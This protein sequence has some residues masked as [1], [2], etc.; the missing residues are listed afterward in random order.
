VAELALVDGPTL[1]RGGGKWQKLGGHFHL[2]EDQ[3]RPASPTAR[4][5]GAARGTVCWLSWPSLPHDAVMA[6]VDV[7]IAEAEQQP[8]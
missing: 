1:E 6:E 5:P 8:R 2:L 3:S 7:I 4:R